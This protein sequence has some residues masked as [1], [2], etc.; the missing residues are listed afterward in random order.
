MSTFVGVMSEVARRELAA[1]RTL[2]LGVVTEV[3]SNEGG[4]GSHHLDCDVRLHGSAL[5]LKG[6]PVAV[7]RPGLSA[8]PRI[9]DLVVIGF[10]DGEVN[11]PVLLGTIHA[12][13]VP[14]PD[15][16]PDEV[17]YKVPD[18]GGKARRVEILMPNGNKL[19]VKDDTVTIDMSGTKVVVESGGR[20][21]LE[22]AGDL[23]LT[24]SGNLSL[25]A[26]GNIE[27]RASGNAAFEASGNASIKG[28][29]TSIA[30]TTQF[31]AG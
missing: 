16:K 9:G 6:V 15:A 30:G 11:G 17:V 24:A 10:V 29:M 12:A 3:A 14:S 2:A 19:T 5:V 20:I 25:Q 18:D 13:D 22:A 4:S 8:L 23:S 1:H 31:K 28:T 7:A 21:A 27:L 26:K